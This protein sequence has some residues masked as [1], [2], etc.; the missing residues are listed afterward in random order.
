MQANRPAEQP[1]RS[2]RRRVVWVSI[3]GVVA[4]ALI[5]T[6][7]VM[8]TRPDGGDAP[9]APQLAVAEP[10]RGKSGTPSA[11]A[12]V[13][14][15]KRASG[16]GVATVMLTD[17]DEHTLWTA[18]ITQEGRRAWVSAVDG[19]GADVGSI[20]SMLAPEGV[21]PV[22]FG[23]NAGARGLLIDA[24]GSWVVE[25][26]AAD[27]SPV[28]SLDAPHSGTASDVLVIE[29]VVEPT[30]ITFSHDG[31]GAVSVVAYS[32]DGDY[33]GLLV[34]GVGELTAGAV[35]PEDTRFVVVDVSTDVG[36]GQWTIA[37]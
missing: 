11:P 12:A 25:I 24:D 32:V 37:S 18:H 35:L 2:S 4:A 16:E 6:A 14:V 3:F 1:K 27:E 29:S 36:I 5:L 8:I 30:K 23:F 7:V 26:S 22:N 17:L 31:N 28:W 9:D 33:L 15:V 19:S 20:S 34:N 13:R 21:Y 10:T